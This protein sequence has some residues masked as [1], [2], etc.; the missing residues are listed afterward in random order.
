MQQQ[1]A[2]AIQ[3]RT[4]S[5]RVSPSNAIVANPP[6]V[7][8]FE[9]NRVWFFIRTSGTHTGAFKFGSDTYEA[10]GKTI[11]GPPE[12]CSYTFNK[13]RGPGAPAPGRRR[14]SGLQGPVQPC[15]V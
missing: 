9:P 7:D 1:D 3:Q 11:Q 5:H 8:K 12:V 2:L 10:T 14:L 13:A 6:Q 15:R 4:P